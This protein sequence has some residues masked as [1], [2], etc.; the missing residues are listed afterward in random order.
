MGYSPAQARAAL[1]KTKS[2][3]DV[4]AAVEIILGQTSSRDDEDDFPEVDEDQV[5]IERRRKE[6]EAERRRKRRAGPSRESVKARSEPKEDQYAEQK[7]MI[8][9]KAGE[10]KQWGLSTATSLWNSGRKLL[11]EQR[12]ALEASELA[13]KAKGPAS[14]S[15]PRWAADA[16]IS[17]D[18]EK[19][20]EGS[21]GFKDIV[22]R[23]TAGRQ[24]GH[25]TTTRDRQ[26]RPDPGMAPRNGKIQES[27]FGDDEPIASG[28]RQSLQP[29]T[30]TK[31]RSPPAQ[32]PKR[33]LITATPS[34]LQTS[35]SKKALGN[36]H[37]KLGRFTEAEQSYSSAISALPTG[38]LFLVPL[39]NNRCA[40]R[41]KLG[42]SAG[43]AEDATMVIELVGAGYHPNREAALPPEIALE[44][45]LSDA[46]VK[47]TTK[48]AQAW[49]M[50]EK[51]SSAL[52]DWE[53][54][55]GFDAVILGTS[56]SGT[57]TLASEGARRARK[58]LEPK[59]QISKAPVQAKA[60]TMS[61]P[62][63]TDKS[64]A[65][66]EL[67][68]ANQAAEAEDAE[69]F[70]AKDTV[71]SKLSAWK[72]GKETNLRALIASLDM[73]LWE[74]IMKGGLKVGMHEL[75][76][77]KQVKIKY[78]KVIA[79]LHPDKVSLTSFPVFTY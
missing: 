63:N 7:E 76:T 14:S 51:W 1:A 78:M 20:T 74:D 42:N 10:I 44:V 72:T 53:R 34:Q 12:K 47:A 39:F 60:K 18:D 21:A 15:R 57:R 70:A 4:E 75:I 52:E 35:R 5:E 45:K 55:L 58:A 43:A 54:L 22:D 2:G 46:V 19:G 41:L 13:K 30:R 48:R 3:R 67:R 31:A 66:A 61:R 37:F 33:T 36:E 6:E 71:D 56:A 29:P 69:R 65:V 24:N 28:S 25:R 16:A 23:N 26:E 50:S 9:E 17:D 49:E 11:E 8:L 77:E 64:Q 79:R 38:H 27:L 32:L 62:A 68:K 40:S 59:V 73:V